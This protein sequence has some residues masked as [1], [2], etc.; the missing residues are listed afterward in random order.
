MGVSVGLI[1]WPRLNID[2]NVYV[3]ERAVKIWIS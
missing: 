1:G 3:G 2:R